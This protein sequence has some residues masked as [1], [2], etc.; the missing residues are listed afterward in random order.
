VVLLQGLLLW[1]EIEGMGDLL[2]S[3]ALAWFGITAEPHFNMPVAVR[4]G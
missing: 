4:E 2:D 3:V 1:L